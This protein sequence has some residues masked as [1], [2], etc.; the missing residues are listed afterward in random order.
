M[1]GCI[2]QEHLECELFDNPKDTCWYESLEDCLCFRTGKYNSVDDI[3]KST[4]IHLYEKKKH[5][6]TLLKKILLKIWRNPR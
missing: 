4:V 2:Y 1:V 6:Y 3:K 5:E